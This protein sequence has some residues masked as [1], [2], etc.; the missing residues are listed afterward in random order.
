MKIKTALIAALPQEVVDL[1]KR[2]KVHISGV[3][4]VNAALTVSNIVQKHPEIELIINLGTVGSVQHPVGSIHQ[5]GHFQDRDYKDPG[6]GLNHFFDAIDFTDQLNKLNISVNQDV[7]C[8]TGDTFVDSLNQYQLVDMEA[9]GIA[10]AC[11]HYELPLL[12]LKYVTDGCDLAS[13]TNWTIV[14]E[15]AQDKLH[16]H[17]TSL[18]HNLEIV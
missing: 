11:K 7:I 10:Q 4:K 3:G 17:F 15:Q 1:A 2:H 12:S 18:E 8:A 9:Y 5:V 14:L 6:L 16:Q 13:A